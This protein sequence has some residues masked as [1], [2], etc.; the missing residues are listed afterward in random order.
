MQL[1]LDLCL[2]E[3]I[4]RGAIQVSQPVQHVQVSLFAG[5]QELKHIVEGPGLG[6]RHSKSLIQV[7]IETIVLHHIDELKFISTDSGN[8]ETMIEV[9][10]VEV[11]LDLISLLQNAID[12]LFAYG[13]D[14]QVDPTV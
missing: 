13:E 9:V 14:G 6:P 10:D 1:A 7:R 4:S 3:I 8:A 5:V 11:D 12:F 2:E